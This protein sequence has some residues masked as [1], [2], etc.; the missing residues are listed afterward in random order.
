MRELARLLVS[1][2]NSGTTGV[3]FLTLI[4]AKDRYWNPLRDF[5]G[6]V[7]LSTDGDDV[8]PTVV[9][10]R[11]GFARVWIT[12][13]R[14]GDR[15][16][17]ATCGNVTGEDTIHIVPAGHVQRTTEPSEEIVKSLVSPQKKPLSWV[18]R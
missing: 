17:R 7:I 18:N 16:V 3:P 12:L 13:T 6:Q 9:T 10:L 8:N 2:P 5:N 11:D 14:V 15:R 1:V 4:A